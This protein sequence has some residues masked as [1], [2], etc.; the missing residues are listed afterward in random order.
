MELMMDL[1]AL[2]AGLNLILL[3]GLFYLYGG[4]AWRTK[5][6]F[7][8][9]LL[10][11]SALLLLHNMITVYSYLTM[12]PF[13]GESVLPYLFAASGLEFGGLAVLLRF[14]LRGY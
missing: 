5:A 6:P 3:V 10:A 14:T 13:F 7:S 1:A 11:F 4:V 12:A 8:F 9:G 2:F